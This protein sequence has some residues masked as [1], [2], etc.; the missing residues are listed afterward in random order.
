MNDLDKTCT[1][2]GETKPFYAFQEYVYH[3]IHG[4][5]DKRTRRCRRCLS[6]LSLA[7]RKRQR[8]RDPV[9][10]REQMRVWRQQTGDARREQQAMYARLRY[11]RHTPDPIRRVTPC[12]QSDP[13]RPGLRRCKD[14]DVWKPLD[15]FIKNTNMPSGYQCQC[16]ACRNEKHAARLRNE[17][18]YAEYVRLRGKI[19]AAEAGR[20]TRA[21]QRKP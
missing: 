13:D 11:R 17:P 20:I 1:K 5:V 19:G 16:R 2:C 15:A 8:D 10:Y 6:S 7:R 21:K 4:P 18:A 9:A 3:G 12:E 14:C